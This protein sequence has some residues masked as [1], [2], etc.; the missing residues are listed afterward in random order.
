MKKLS[1]T[2]FKNFYDENEPMTFIFDTENQPN[3]ETQDVKIVQRYIQTAFMLN[4][5][6][7]MFANSRGT[8]CLNRVK[9]IR[10]YKETS[11]QGYLLS[12]VCGAKD[13]SSDDTSYTFL[14]D[15][16]NFSE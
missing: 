11:I 5:N 7:L 2:E 6:R 8:F 16:K 3:G 10:L 13:N 12:V 14:A 9:Y 15:P 4:P 1:I